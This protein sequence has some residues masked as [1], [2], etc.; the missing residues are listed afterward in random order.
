MGLERITW[1]LYMSAGRMGRNNMDSMYICMSA[2][3]LGR[4]N[5]DSIYVGG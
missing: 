5:M 4:N 3:R 2:G 1:I